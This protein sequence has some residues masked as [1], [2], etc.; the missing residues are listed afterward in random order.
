MTAIR[1]AL[2]LFDPRFRHSFF[3]ET[4][5]CEGQIPVR[6]KH[7]PVCHCDP[8]IFLPVCPPSFPHFDTRKKNKKPFRVCLFSFGTLSH[9][10]EDLPVMKVSRLKLGAF[11][12]ASWEINGA[13]GFLHSS[14]RFPLFSI[15]RF[16]CINFN[17]RRCASLLSVQI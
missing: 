5:P 11:L 17:Y 2:I 16:Y 3:W 13:K 12:I 14:A 10:Y 8:S 6:L 9:I 4:S 15:L 1:F 7:P